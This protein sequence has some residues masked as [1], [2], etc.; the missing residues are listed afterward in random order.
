MSAA[1]R[2]SMLSDGLYEQVINDG[3]DSEPSAGGK[4]RQT[5]HIDSAEA[6]WVLA[7]HMTFFKKPL[8]FGQN[9]II[10]KLQRVAQLR[11]SS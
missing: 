11:K 7:R 2:K 8:K 4:L 1:N 6:S 3:M 9:W 10:N 5:A